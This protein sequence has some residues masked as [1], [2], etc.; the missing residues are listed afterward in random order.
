[1]IKLCS[2]AFM[3]MAMNYVPAEDWQSGLTLSY[4]K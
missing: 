1:M 2:T 4:H 3:N